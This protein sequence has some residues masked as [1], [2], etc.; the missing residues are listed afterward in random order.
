MPELSQLSWH[1]GSASAYHARGPVIDPAQCQRGFLRKELSKQQSR[2]F[3]QKQS[4]IDHNFTNANVLKRLEV[5]IKW[6]RLDSGT[7]AL[8]RAKVVIVGYWASRTLSFQAC[9]QGEYKSGLPC[10]SSTIPNQ[11]S[12]KNS[13]ARRTVHYYCPIY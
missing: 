6:P 4:G 8:F 2:N 7:S 12:H 1:N 5:S 13:L 10:I 11:R 3:C 9:V